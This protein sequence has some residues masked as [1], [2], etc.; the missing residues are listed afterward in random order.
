MRTVAAGRSVLG[1]RPQGHM[2]EHVARPHRRRLGAV[3][4]GAGRS[5]VRHGAEGQLLCVHLAA[6]GGGASRG[7]P[8]F[9]APGAVRGGGCAAVAQ[10]DTGAVARAAAVE[11]AI[12]QVVAAIGDVSD[13]VN[14][15][16]GRKWVG[17]L[18]IGND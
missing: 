5:A 6:S 9:A 12:A 17:T 18:W 11:E 3:S 1:G 7:V 13:G 2:R 14:E 16:A 15:N 10:P 8:G 4:A